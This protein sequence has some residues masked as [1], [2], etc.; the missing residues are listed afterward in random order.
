MVEQQFKK[1]VN[2]ITESQIETTGFEFTRSMLS[3]D[4]IDEL[5]QRF[6]QSKMSL[7]KIQCHEIDDDE[8]YQICKF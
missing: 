8:D 6:D 5:D 4:H 3:L 7:D 1:F 2:Y